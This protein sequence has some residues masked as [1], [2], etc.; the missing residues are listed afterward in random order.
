MGPI[1][2]FLGARLFSSL[3][4]GPAGVALVLHY[5]LG[6]HTPPLWEAQTTLTGFLHNT[7]LR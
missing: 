1:T 4:P 2:F 5:L 6:L 7:S 3:L